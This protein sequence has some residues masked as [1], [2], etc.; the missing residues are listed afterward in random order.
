[1][2]HGGWHEMGERKAA[3]GPTGAWTVIST[4]AL[5]PTAKPTHQVPARGMMG[6]T[7]GA[8]QEYH[9]AGKTNRLQQPRQRR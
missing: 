3:G 9:T 4:A 2:G 1:M 7:W 6:E 5:S 8:T